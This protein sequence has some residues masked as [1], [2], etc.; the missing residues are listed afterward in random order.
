MGDKYDSEE[1]FLEGYDYNMWSENN[2]K[3]SDYKESIDK[4]E[5]ADKKKSTKVPPMPP[6]ESD[7]KDLKEGKGLKILFQTN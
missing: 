5:S 7:E 3:L 6:L 2:E 1:L 4:E